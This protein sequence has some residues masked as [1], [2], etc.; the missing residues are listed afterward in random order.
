MRNGGETMALKEDGHATSTNYSKTN[1]EVV[2]TSL[3]ESQENGGFET[4]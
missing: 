4:D 2:E 3:T 1:P